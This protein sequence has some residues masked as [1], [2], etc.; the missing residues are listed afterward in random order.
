ME[1]QT[2]EDIN[3]VEKTTLEKDNNVIDGNLMWLHIH[4]LDNIETY[5]QDDEQ[6]GDIDD[7]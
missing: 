4:N 7:Q 1:D 5:A 6:H 3:K 2:I